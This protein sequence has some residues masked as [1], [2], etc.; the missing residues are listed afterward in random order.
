MKVKKMNT[1][2]YLMLLLRLKR[3]KG[4]SN[5]NAQQRLDAAIV[6]KRDFYSEQIQMRTNDKRN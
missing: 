5:N 6:R 3:K 2:N 4:K 1:T